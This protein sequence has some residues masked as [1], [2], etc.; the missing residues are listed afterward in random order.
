[1]KPLPA[2]AIAIANFVSV[3]AFLDLVAGVPAIEGALLPF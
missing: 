3:Y 1:M 2:A